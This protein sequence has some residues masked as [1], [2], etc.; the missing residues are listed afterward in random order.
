MEQTRKYQWGASDEDRKN[1][2]RILWW[3][4]TFIV[5]FVVA[6]KAIESER[7]ENGSSAIVATIIVSLLGVRVILAHRQFLRDPD[8][9]MRKIQL[10]SLALAHG[11]GVVAG[12]SYTLLLSADIV[13]ETTAL[14][15]V[16]IMIVTYVV[17][18]LVSM[19][20]YA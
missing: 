13:S 8:E 20:R 15:L 3:S 17:S 16:A 4:L 5:L 19:R 11:V 10:D 1:Q 14:N 9:L 7:I 6:S 12:F 18:M 2:R